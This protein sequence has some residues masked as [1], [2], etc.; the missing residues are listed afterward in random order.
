MAFCFD[1]A[2]E[3][4]LSM[5]SFKEIKKDGSVYKQEYWIKEPKWNDI[6]ENK[7]HRNNNSELIEEMKNKLEKYI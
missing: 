4:I 2:C 1:E 6:K 7:I 5:R 3:Y